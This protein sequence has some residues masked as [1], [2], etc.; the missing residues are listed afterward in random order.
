MTVRRRATEVAGQQSGKTVCNGKTGG[1]KARNLEEPQSWKTL[2]RPPES[3][4]NL[5][6]DSN[7]LDII[8]KKIIQGSDTTV[9]STAPEDEQTHW[10]QTI[11]YSSDPIEVTLR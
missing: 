5:S 8:R 10:R 9:V 11:F 2:C 4:Q 7:P 3:S 1:C 6:S